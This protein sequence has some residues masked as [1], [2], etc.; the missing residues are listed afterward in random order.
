[1]FT[2]RFSA[3]LMRFVVA[4]A[5][6]HGGVSGAGS[7]GTTLMHQFVLLD[8]LECVYATSKMSTLMHANRT[9]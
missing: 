8:S 6:Y 7:E 4:P 5:I 9:P 2:N 3:S 1:M